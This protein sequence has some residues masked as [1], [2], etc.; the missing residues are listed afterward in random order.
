MK[1]LHVSAR[2]ILIL[3][4]LLIIFP[5]AM[6]L[7]ACGDDSKTYQATLNSNELHFG[8][9]MSG[10]KTVSSNQGEISLCGPAYYDY[11]EIKLLINDKEAS[12]LFT[13]SDINYNTNG[14]IY[15][16]TFN[17]KKLTSDAQITVTGLKDRYARFSYMD[18]V[19]TQEYQTLKNTYDDYYQTYTSYLTAA[20]DTSK[21]EEDRQKATANANSYKRYLDD[22][23]DGKSFDAWYNSKL[24]LISNY[25][26]KLS[27]KDYNGLTTEP[28]KNQ[29]IGNTNRTYAECISTEG[30]IKLGDLTNIKNLNGGA[31]QFEYTYRELTTHDEHGYT[32]GLLPIICETSLGRTTVENRGYNDRDSALYFNKVGFIEYDENDN[33]IYGMVN[34]NYDYDSVLPVN[35]I[36][37]SNKHIVLSDDYAHRLYLDTDITS[38]RVNVYHTYAINPTGVKYAKLNLQIENQNFTGFADLERDGFVVKN[39]GDTVYEIDKLGQLYFYTNENGETGV[40]EDKIILNKITVNGQICYWYG[41]ITYQNNMAMIG[42]VSWNSYLYY[43]T[44]NSGLTNMAESGSTQEGL[45]QITSDMV[46]DITDTVNVLVSANDIEYVYNAPQSAGAREE[47][48]AANSYSFDILLD[49]EHNI[50]WDNVKVKVGGIVNGNNPVNLVELKDNYGSYTVQECLFRKWNGGIG[51]V[52]VLHCVLNVNQ[53]CPID[54][55][56]KDDLLKS[57]GIGISEF[58]TYYISVEGADFSNTTGL[59]KIKGTSNVDP[60]CFKY[61]ENIHSNGIY[62]NDDGTA[63]EAINTNQM[64]GFTGPYIAI[65][66]QNFY[67][68]R[69]VNSESYSGPGYYAVN[70]IANLN[71]TNNP[72]SSLNQIEQLKRMMFC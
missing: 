47:F 46:E 59:V 51:Y 57:N 37:A 67:D 1:N 17:A 22:K 26:I 62:K 49:S 18:F 41:L 31:Y 28:L 8:S 55:L 4:C 52:K 63:Y 25:R 72:N 13:R 38:S 29:K 30:Y 6:F 43:D 50:N 20:N 9:S 71:I 53:C 33:A 11:S 32:I 39:H 60:D 34:S 24:S 61:Y 70:D 2:K 68:N 7:A 69:N 14:E 44:N 54:L 42:D 65:S 12:G 66:G 5:C 16:G 64:D 19:D 58:N 45:I 48:S 35:Q 36:Y 27:E 21:T 15:I 3:L 56:T 23:F 10:S 40:N